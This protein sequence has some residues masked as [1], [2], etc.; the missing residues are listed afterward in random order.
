LGQLWVFHLILLI[1]IEF[2]FI[3]IEVVF[4]GGCKLLIIE[5]DWWEITKIWEICRWETQTWFRKDYQVKRRC[6][7]WTFIIVY[8]FDDHKI[9]YHI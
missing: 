7:P 8:Y 5:G 2:L 3:G 4:N 1:I 9:T 6:L